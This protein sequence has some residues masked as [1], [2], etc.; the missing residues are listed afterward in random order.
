MKKINDIHGWKLSGLF[1]LV[2]ILYVGVC[3]AATRYV[4][5]AGGHVPPFTS[6]TSAATNIQ[7]ALDI[8]AAGDTVLVTNGVYDSGYRILESSNSSTTH[9]SRCRIMVTNQITVRSVNGPDATVI[10]GQGPRGE[11]A[12]RCAYLVNGARLSGFTLREGQTYAYGPAA[13]QQGGGA[14]CSSSVVI[15]NCVVTENVATYGGGIYGGT[16]VNSM[17]A[18]NTA[19]GLDGTYWRDRENR[20]YGGGVYG[21]EVRGSVISGNRCD[22][23]GAGAFNATLTLCRLTDNYGALKGAGA[24][25]SDLKNCLVARNRAIGILRDTYQGAPRGVLFGTGGGAWHCNLWNCTVIDNDA[26]ETC[27]GVYRCQAWNS[28]VYWNRAPEYPNYNGDAGRFSSRFTNC[29]VTPIPPGVGNTASAPALL[30][31]EEGRFAGSSPAFDSGCGDFVKTSVD[32]DNVARTNNGAVD[33]GAFEY[34]APCPTGQPI[35]VAMAVD[36]PWAPTGFV[37]HFESRIKGPVAGYTW[38]MGDGTIVSNQVLVDHAYAA[39]GS[40]DVVLS[41][42]AGGFTLTATTRVEVSAIISAPGSNGTTRFVSLSGGHVPPFASWADAATNIQAAIDVSAPGNL[43]LVTNGLYRTGKRVVHGMPTRV[44]VTRP[45]TVRSVNGPDVTAIEGG[46]RWDSDP[47]RC[48]Y[49]F[50]HARLDGFTLTNGCTW[51][52]GDALRQQSGGG[53]FCETDAVLEDCALVANHAYVQGGGVYGG[54]LRDCRLRGNGCARATGTPSGN[55]GAFSSTGRGGGACRSDLLGCEI[56]GNG[57]A[58]EGGGLFECVA[59]DCILDGNRAISSDGRSVGGAYAYT[60]GKGGAAYASTLTRCELTANEAGEYGGATYNCTLTS[61]QLTG[62]RVD[63]GYH[64][65]SGSY[66]YGSGGAIYGGFARLC[67]I[68]NNETKKYGGGT[69]DAVLEN[70]LLSGNRVA[71]ESSSYYDPGAIFGA[72]GGAC[73]GSLVNCT[74]VDNEAQLQGGG[75]YAANLINCIVCYNASPSGPEMLSCSSSNCCFSDPGLAGRYNLRLLLGSPCINAGDNSPV[76]WSKDLAG[77]PRIAEGQVDIG[78]Y[79]FSLLGAFGTLN[80]I[81]EVANAVDVLKGCPIEF[82]AIVE[83]VPLGYLWDWDDGAFDLNTYN[84]THAFASGGTYRVVFYA[85]NAT[86]VA[87]FPVVITVVDVDDLYVSPSGGHVYPFDTWERAA[88]NIQAA[89]DICGSGMTIFLTNGHYRLDASVEVRAGCTLESVNGEEVTIVDGQDAVRCFHLTHSNAVLRGLSITGGRAD[90]GAGVL[91][92]G[93]LIEDCLIYANEA[94]NSSF[95][96]SCSGPFFAGYGGGVAIERGVVRDCLIHNNQAGDGAGVYAA[97]G[98]CVETCL[99]ISNTSHTPWYEA[100]GGGVY[101]DNSILKHC[102]VRD[103]ASYLE[104]GGVYCVA[105]SLVENCIIAGNYAWMTGGGAQ[106]SQNSTV[107]NCVIFSNKASMAAGS[108]LENSTMEH[109][110]VVGNRSSSTGAGLELYRSNVV[111]NCIV[112][113]NENAG[114]PPVLNVRHVGNSASSISYSLVQPLQDGIGNI[115]EVPLF[116]NATNGDYRLLAGSPGI[117]AGVNLPEIMADCEGTPRPLDGNGDGVARADMGAYEY[118]HT[119]YLAKEGS[120]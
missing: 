8:C 94:T 13:S 11:S 75:A 2:F 88:T 60:R 100:A 118:V 18:N 34:Y 41:A 55:A 70:C 9:Y 14:Y 86:H 42:E 26:A 79:E 19:T 57:A 3:E 37:Q 40:Y 119:H 66:D 46:N 10:V 78:A 6:W 21:S 104:G 84:P 101:C 90:H 23:T 39:P 44:A 61:C 89:A 87:S 106:G 73:R 15:S 95:S 28:I 82:E 69:C 113:M 35:Q 29:C 5:L 81:V 97:A 25:D 80:A 71:G 36:F 109:C 67:M 68:E 56:R 22:H 107:R 50:Y 98:A 12:V 45:I 31:L 116:V 32:L 112:V 103:N 72:G 33:M 52:H 63:G 111:R 38:D 16:V 62:N 120:H 20:G 105:T 83:G 65:M 85:W 58:L 17:I 110:T 1:A 93:G 77:N 53:A 108:Y 30:S 114:D 64:G 47:V 24:S 96:W 117:D 74:I 27:G 91:A 76:T 54:A 49:L 99:I 48:A 92:E 7:A 115:A 43:V 4:S 59:V 102:E 51:A